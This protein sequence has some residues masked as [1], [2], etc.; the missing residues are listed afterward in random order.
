MPRQNDVPLVRQYWLHVNLWHRTV[1]PYA[2]RAV[3]REVQAVAASD[4]A[5]AS[6]HDGA[7]AVEDSHLRLRLRL[8]LQLRDVAYRNIAFVPALARWGA[9]GQA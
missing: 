6:G 9:G 1:L 3:L 4:A 7:L 8:R 2:L 5:G